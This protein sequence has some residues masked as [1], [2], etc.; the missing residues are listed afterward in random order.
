[1]R[2]R[3]NKAIAT[4]TLMMMIL[5]LVMP[6]GAFAAPP[7][8]NPDYTFTESEANDGSFTEQFQVELGR[9]RG[10]LNKYT[11]CEIVDGSLPE[12]LKLGLPPPMTIM[13][14]T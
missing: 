9:S 5:T 1:M 7:A 13:W 8:D 6:V 3:F 12:G 11:S 10:L 14:L 2:K 4:L